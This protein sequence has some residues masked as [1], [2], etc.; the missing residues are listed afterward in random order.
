MLTAITAVSPDW[1]IGCGDDLLYKDMRDL[2]FFSGFTQEKALI[3]GHNT[4]KTLPKMSN[5]GVITVSR[6]MEEFFS[7]KGH[8]EGEKIFM[9]QFFLKKVL[10]GGAKTYKLFAPFVSKIYITHFFNAP[11]KQADVFFPI[12]DYPWIVPE[13]GVKIVSNKDFEIVLYSKE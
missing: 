7:K 13:N 9:Q 10:I 12:E 8:Q 11:E 6:S 3:V 5:R 4:A 1:G 2:Y